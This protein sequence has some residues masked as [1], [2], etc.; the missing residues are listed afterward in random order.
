[1]IRDLVFNILFLIT[2]DMIIFFN[3]PRKYK[4]Y[5][6][7]K[8]YMIALKMPMYQKILICKILFISIITIFF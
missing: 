5:L 2:I 7:F 8:H 4:K 1:M 6:I 3:Y